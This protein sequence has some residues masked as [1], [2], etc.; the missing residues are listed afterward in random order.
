MYMSAH[1]K[2]SII[3]TSLILPVTDGNLKLGMWQGIYLGE[4]RDNA[5]ARR[6]VVT[7]QGSF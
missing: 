5:G 3:G 4:H 2:S 6:L 1:V 7:L